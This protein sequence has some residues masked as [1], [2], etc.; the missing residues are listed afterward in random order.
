[1]RHGPNLYI[2]AGGGGGGGLAVSNDDLG[3]FVATVTN[4]S[5]SKSFDVTGTA[6]SITV[7]N[8]QWEVSDDDATWGSS[9]SDV[10]DATVY[11]RYAPSLGGSATP[12][13]VIAVDGLEVAVD[14]PG[15]NPLVSSNCLAWCLYDLV[16]EHYAE[17]SDF[18]LSGWPSANQANPDYELPT[19]SAGGGPPE[20]MVA[21]RRVQ[22]G[23][24]V[25]QFRGTHNTPV[26]DFLE[27]ADD[28]AMLLNSS[29]IGSTASGGLIYHSTS[30]QALKVVRGSA[31]EYFRFS[32]KTYDGTPPTGFDLDWFGV[33]APRNDV[34]TVYRGAAKG[35]TFSSIP[36]AAF[37]TSIGY[38][39]LGD[40]SGAGLSEWR[41]AN[42][43]LFREDIDADYDD[44]TTY[45]SALTAAAEAL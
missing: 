39:I 22:L 37:T 12:G 28:V 34:L 32:G 45:I 43:L 23:V 18:D 24:G 42:Y 3:D 31:G 21:E 38:V 8:N 4:A 44:Y 25:R 5:E 35:A 33:N 15:K 13:G 14:I 26:N 36:D 10:T 30:L 11:V 9:L 16:I 41:V 17:V 6:S 40:V 27:G 1:M 20:Y 7:P 29:L 2:R 19:I